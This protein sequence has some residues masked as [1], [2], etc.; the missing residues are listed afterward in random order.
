[1][2]RLHHV[3]LAV[4]DIP[5]AVTWYADR[6]DVLVEYQDASWAM[7]RLDN[8]NLALVLPEEHPPHIAVER[9]DAGA[10]G[11]LQKHRDGTSSVYV[12]DPWGN[13]IEFLKCSGNIQK[14]K[15]GQIDSGTEV[16]FD[17]SCPLCRS[18][19]N[20][21][22]KQDRTGRLKFTDVSAPDAILPE[23]LEKGAAMK[24]FHVFSASGEKL[25]GAAAFIELWAQLPGWR[26]VAAIARLRPLPW[27]LEFLYQCF[28][29][30][31]PLIVRAFTRRAKCSSEQ[32]GDVR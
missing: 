16:F 5:A 2:T 30:L 10:F 32:P 7:L 12:E 31:R 24:R 19:I 6:F 17:G 9:E 25:S 4:C 13:T 1:M 8:L 14:Q 22:R 15:I 20:L 26:Y 21:Y 18:E 29:P 27:I 11:K 28:L 23:G 3:A